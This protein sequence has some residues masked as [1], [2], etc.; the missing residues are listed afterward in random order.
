MIHDTDTHLP[1]WI[2]W[3]VL[4]V[5]ACMIDEDINTTFVH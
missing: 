5:N 4:P 3:S 1:L 2:C